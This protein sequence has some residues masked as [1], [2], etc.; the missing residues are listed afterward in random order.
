M[1]RERITRE[2]DNRAKRITELDSLRDAQ[3]KAQAELEKIESDIADQNKKATEMLM[4]GENFD[5]VDATIRELQLR[6]ETL[7]SR[8]GIYKDL[9]PEAER[10][11]DSARRKLT[12]AY[13][14]ESVTQKSD[15][16]K[17]ISEKLKEAMDMFD[18]YNEEVAKELYELDIPLTAGSV[19][20]SPM[21]VER[22]L[23]QLL[24]NGFL[25]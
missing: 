14:R 8:L 21:P 18:Y 17:M 6:K 4:K 3:E 16:A 25:I 20:L 5:K 10:N 19:E 2:L 13:K 12:Q 7:L 1:V 22:R 15:A 9:I 23:K 11:L 24:I